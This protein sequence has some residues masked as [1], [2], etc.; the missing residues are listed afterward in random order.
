MGKVAGGT[1]AKKRCKIGTSASREGAVGRRGGCIATRIL[2][3]VIQPSQS[4]AAQSRRH[5]VLWLDLGRGWRLPRQ[6]FSIIGFVIGWA[7]EG[8]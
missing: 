4:P 3:R 1:S 2:A 6:L 8:E 7:G 5:H